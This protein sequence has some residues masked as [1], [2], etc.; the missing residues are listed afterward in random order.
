MAS[1]LSLVPGNVGVLRSID[2][3]VCVGLRP[4]APRTCVDVR[5][6]SKARPFPV[7]RVSSDQDVSVKSSGLSI[8]E[9]EAAAVAGNF[10]D[11]PPLHKPQG[12]A[13]TPVVTPL[14]CKENGC[15]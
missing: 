1:I 15:P 9:C 3:K 5:R 12:P 11:P 4:L 8:E 7:V 10:P 14:V 6:G 13:G 2:D